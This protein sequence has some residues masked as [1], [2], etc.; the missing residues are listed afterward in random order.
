MSE[1]QTLFAHVLVPVPVPKAYTYRVP[2]DW[3]DW[4]HE[5]LRVAVQFG[6]KKIYA[7]IILSLSDLPP[8]GYQA[9]YLLDVLDESPIVN[10]KQLQFWQWVAKYYMCYMGEVMATALPAG[11]RLQSETKILLHPDADLELVSKVDVEEMEWQILELLGK[12]DGV[13]LDEI[14]QKLAVKNVLKYVKSLYLRGLVV[15]EE[16][17]KENY[18]PKFEEFLS[19]SSLWEDAELANL[20]L[21]AL[22][23]KAPK[24]Y[25][26]IMQVL[27]TGKRE[28]AVADLVK[29]MA[30]DRTV[31]KQLEKKE[32]VVIQKRRRDHLQVIRGGE[33][34]FALTPEQQ[35]Q[36]P[37]SK[38]P[39]ISKNPPCYSV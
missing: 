23:R 20:R 34:N 10:H 3:N 26:A 27:G 22:E 30:L 11:Y 35:K 2:H 21:N 1:L 25:E 14:H 4:I 13:S 12:K 15:M 19:L 29:G 33:Q 9:S 39:L 38:K 32:L 31:L 24:Q 18:R 16:E 37:S 6:P 36:N 7:G 28:L 17:L 8:E 5:G